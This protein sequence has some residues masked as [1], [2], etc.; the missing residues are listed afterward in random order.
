[1]A[2]LSNT[3]AGTAAATLTT[4]NTAGPNQFDSVFGT[5]TIVFDGTHPHSGTTGLLST[6]TASVAKT[7]YAVWDTQIVTAAANSYYRE[8]VYITA[9]PTVMAALA[10]TRSGTGGVSAGTILQITATGVLRIS[11]STGASVA[12]TVATFPLNTPVRVEYEVTGVSGTTGT[13]TGRFFSGANLEG[14]TPDT[15]GTCTASGVAVGGLTTALRVGQV[16]TATMTTTWNLWFDDVA[17]SDTAQPGSSTSATPITVAAVSAAVS[18]VAEPIT[19]TASSTVTSIVLG[20][21]STVVLNAPT[22]TTSTVAVQVTRLPTVVARIAFDSQPADPAPVWTVVTP[23][24]AN[25]PITMSRGRTDEFADVQ[26]GKLTMVLDNSDGRFTPSAVSPYWPGVKINRPVQLAYIWRGTTYIRW[27]GF[28]DS[29]PTGWPGGTS[30]YSEV[31]LTATDILKPMARYRQLGPVLH[32][33]IL[34]DNP[35][36]YWPMDDPDGGTTGLANIAPTPAGRLWPVQYGPNAGVTYGSGAAPPTTSGAVDFKRAADLAADGTQSGTTF[37]T[38][39][40][41]NLYD[42]VSQ[43]E[44][45]TV[46]AWFTSVPDDPT[47][48]TN[49]RTIVWVGDAYGGV[50]TLELSNV[51]GG[52]RRLYFR[53]TNMFVSYTLDGG[54]FDQLKVGVHHVVGTVLPV[55]GALMS[56]VMSLWLDGVR[57]A[58]SPP[59]GSSGFGIAV[60]VGGDSYQPRDAT[61]YLWQGSISNVALFP[62]VLSDNR[63]RDHY[64][65]GSTGFAGERSDQRFARWSRLAGLT[66]TTIELGGTVIGLQDSNGQSVLQLL[67]AVAGAEQGRLDTSPA[68]NGVLLQTRAHRYNQTAKFTVDAS[69]V[70]GDIAF[71]VDD[72]LLVNDLTLTRPGGAPSG[73]RARNRLSEANYGPYRQTDATILNTDAQLSDAATWKVGVYGTPVARVAAVTIDLY[74]I[75]DQALITSILQAT[76]GDLFTITG[77]PLSAPATSVSLCV[78]GISGTLGMS[79]WTVTFATSPSVYGQA[80]FL[81]DPINSLLGVST[82]LSY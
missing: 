50:Y 25:T 80:W 37:G 52:Q 21:T 27:S 1:M 77:L 8:Y 78:E 31:P 28:I 64:H 3:C 62:T 36:G 49:G 81:G 72:A 11:D 61:R 58:Q 79:E 54:I 23:W 7:A 5:G 68:T 38:K 30:T 59:V 51:V 74:T 44:R 69:L 45:F 53:S 67:Q 40:G 6:F 55:P 34:Y 63:I 9:L 10:L 56:T 65:A 43:E 16:A 13:V 73:V 35:A 70:N 48:L 41:L 20:D 14:T 42:T 60:G 2:A 66:N 26:P 71:T 82:N 22:G 17:W 39:T 76:T 33:E 46:E 12:T 19:V 57:L 15:N 47:A 29:W 75:G 32:E 4:A 24:V 18:S